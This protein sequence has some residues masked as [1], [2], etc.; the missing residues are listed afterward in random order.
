MFQFYHLISHTWHTYKQHLVK[1]YIFFLLIFVLFPLMFSPLK[2]LF[3]A[4]NGSIFW[5]SILIT[6]FLSVEFLFKEEFHIGFFEYLLQQQK[7]LEIYIIFKIIIFWLFNIFPL[8]FFGFLY[9]ILFFDFQ[10]KQLLLFLFLLSLQTL[11]LTFLNAIGSVFLY[12]TQQN[13][14]LIFLILV[15][16]MIPIILFG[17]N[18]VVVGLYFEI[19]LFQIL[20]ICGNFCFIL[21]LVPWL[22]GYLIKININ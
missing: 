4:F 17:I 2:E 13:F 7:Y 21:F 19:T 22:I 16:L 11:S 8:I 20:I 10:I 15:P 18:F 3:Y 1:S 6:N 9:C 5:F 12:N 14:L